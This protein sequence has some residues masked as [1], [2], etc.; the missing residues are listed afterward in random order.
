MSF[1]VDHEDIRREVD[2]PLNV[3]GPPEELERLAVA[4]LSGLKR[5]AGAER[6]WCSVAGGEPLLNV[7]PLGWKDAATVP[8]AYTCGECDHSGEITGERL[9][10][11]EETT[12]RPEITCEGC[13]KKIALTPAGK[14][15]DS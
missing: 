11:F 10:E 8:M 7:R 3:S 14:G 1:Y 5:Y 4:I 6:V 12:M 13:G 9:R 15:K 2:G